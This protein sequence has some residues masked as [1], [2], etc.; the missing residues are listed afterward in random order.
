MMASI[1]SKGVPTKLDFSNTIFKILVVIIVVILLITLYIFFTSH[2]STTLYNVTH[3]GKIISSS[4][5]MPL[6]S[7]DGVNTAL[8]GTSSGLLL[9]DF[10]TRTSRILNSSRPT[11]L[12]FDGQNYLELQSDGTL[13][14]VSLDDGSLQDIGTGY[15]R[16]YD[17]VDGYLITVD[18]VTS[19]TG[20]SGS[21]AP[22]NGDYTFVKLSIS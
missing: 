17:T 1:C 11:G 12:A 7:S 18:N 16:L 4:D 15:T 2:S 3:D 13:H 10:K 8:I 20:G 5:T 19:V 14:T 22:A 6:L 9:Y 21:K